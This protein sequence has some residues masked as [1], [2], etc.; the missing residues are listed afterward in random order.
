M[1]FVIMIVKVPESKNSDAKKLDVLGAVLV[2]VGLAG[3]TYGF[4]ESS[5]HGFGNPVIL[6]VLFQNPRRLCS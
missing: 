1:V 3:I 2:T 6:T 5:K 4:I